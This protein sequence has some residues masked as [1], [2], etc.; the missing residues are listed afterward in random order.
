MNE[1]GKTSK[2]K[3]LSIEKQIIVA[4]MSRGYILKKTK[5]DINKGK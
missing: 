2:L 1:W 3:K 4:S 5:E